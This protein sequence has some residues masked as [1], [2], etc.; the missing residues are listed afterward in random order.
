MKEFT[1]RFWLS[2]GD[3]F[4]F[5]EEFADEPDLERRYI[6]R[7]EVLGDGTVTELSECKGPPEKVETVIDNAERTIDVMAAG[8]ETTFYYVHFRPEPVVRKMMEGRRETS[9]ALKMPIELRTD[10]SLV[11]T[12][13]G[14][15]SNLGD[16]F[17][18]LPDE[19]NGELLRIQDT[20]AG[21]DG[22]FSAL[23]ERQREVLETAVGLGY[24]DTQQTTTQDAIAAELDISA[25]TVGEHLRKIEAKILGAFAG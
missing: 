10:G 17:E 1:I 19:V 9:L 23:T 12:F 7:M 18:L 3:L 13:I 16:T 8:G 4:V 24:Y 6:H 21:T 14:K 20:T 2:D 5:S 11:A 22:V 25:A 15:Q